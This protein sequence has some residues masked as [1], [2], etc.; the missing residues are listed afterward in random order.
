MHVLQWTLHKN[1]DILLSLYRYLS[2]RLDGRVRGSGVGYPPWNALVAQG[3][4]KGITKTKKKCATRSSD[5]LEIIHTD[6]SGPLTP[7]ICG[8]KFFI[9]FIDDFSQYGY[10]YLIK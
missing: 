6:I 2:L 8:N 9:T 7:T 1:L 4:I 3:E 10:I 5:L